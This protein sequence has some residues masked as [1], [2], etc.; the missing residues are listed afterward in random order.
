ME[1]NKCPSCGMEIE[2][3]SNFCS[4]CGAKI[5]ILCDSIAPSNTICRKCGNIC[6]NDSAFCS[7]CGTA[8][9]KSPNQHP[10]D[11]YLPTFNFKIQS[12]KKELTPKGMW[13]SRLIRSSI[14]LITSIIFMVFC[15]LPIIKIQ[16]P[17]GQSTTSKTELKLTAIDTISFTLAS[18]ENIS[19]DDIKNNELA[20]EIEFLT[21][22]LSDSLGHSW[23]TYDYDNMSKPEQKLYDNIVKKT[24]LL[25]LKTD[26]APTTPLII[27]SGIFSLFFLISCISL[28]IFSFI[29]L[30]SLLGITKMLP[31]RLIIPILILWSIP[32]LLL[33]IIRFCA[34]AFV[35]GIGGVSLAP[36]AVA[37]LILSITGFTLFIIV[38]RLTNDI[39][40]HGSII[41]SLVNLFLAI[42]VIISILS[43]TLYTELT[44]KF[45]GKTNSS[46]VDFSLS[47]DFFESFIMSDDEKSEYEDIANKKTEG[48]KRLLKEQLEAFSSLEIK[49]VKNGGANY[50]NAALLKLG[51]LMDG[52]YEYAIVF[53][54][55]PIACVI[56][57][58]LTGIITLQNLLYLCVGKKN[59]NTVLKIINAT[60]A[61][62]A[63]VPV[64]VFV[65]IA[66][67]NFGIYMPTNYTVK[68]G[69]GIICMLIFSLCL[70]FVP[71]DKKVTEELPTV[72]NTT[73]TP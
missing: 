48:K 25:S 42:A 26:E 15:F 12:V 72:S 49:Y 28:T 37:F 47:A 73:D 50:A 35:H 3:D 61:L 45:H 38:A 52:L 29:Y 32:S 59:K 23:S 5:I 6:A 13:T 70:I 57:L 14:I 43:P 24:I 8:L 33:I 34:S 36:I 71:S 66:S 16:I 30:L 22:T 7:K 51:T 55:T 10:D 17:T 2:Q 40:E 67:N 1:K 58:V 31:S 9:R 69:V 53:I 68:I 46:T 20:E 39:K 64:I 54:V 60:F 56:S 41:H 65:A 11:E 4:S 62:L 18:I 27:I 44:T 21:E 63:L 19:A